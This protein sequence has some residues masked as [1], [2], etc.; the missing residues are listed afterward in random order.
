M[1]RRKVLGVWI[2]VSVVAV[3]AVTAYLVMA[4]TAALPQLQLIPTCSGSY[5][6]SGYRITVAAHTTGEICI[7]HDTPFCL[8]VG[9]MG[10]VTS[11][12][13]TV[14]CGGA[15]GYVMGSEVNCCVSWVGQ[16]GNGIAALGQTPIGAP[17]AVTILSVGPAMV[18]V[19]SSTSCSD[20]SGYPGHAL[21]IVNN[22]GSPTVASLTY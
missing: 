15:T 10:P 12:T 16:N 21:R 11:A 8:I 9:Y 13:A 19:P 4:Q 17:S 14:P 3:L 1:S 5:T 18:Q 7:P 2:V 6:P 20:A 22:G